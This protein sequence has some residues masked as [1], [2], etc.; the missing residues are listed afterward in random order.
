MLNK[1]E[2]LAMEFN[3]L[4]LPLFLD[5][6]ISIFQKRCNGHVLQC[7]ALTTSW[8]LKKD[9]FIKAVLHLI[10]DKKIR[11]IDKS[12]EMDVINV[13]FPMKF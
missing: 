3:G 11:K 5:C 1:S 4:Y 13:V 10:L 7:Q 6:Q 8:F 2:L 12:L 9:I